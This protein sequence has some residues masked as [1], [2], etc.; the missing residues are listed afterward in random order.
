[1]DQ[2]FGIRADRDCYNAVRG[3]SHGHTRA[4]SVA[5][6]HMGNV[7]IH[8]HESHR[9][10][11][12]FDALRLGYVRDGDKEDI[13]T[14]ELAY[15]SHSFVPPPPNSTVISSVIGGPVKCAR[16]FSDPKFGPIVRPPPTEPF[17]AEAI[18]NL[19][20]RHLHPVESCLLRGSATN[21]EPHET[22]VGASPLL[23][24]VPQL[25]RGSSA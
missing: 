15:H 11:T 16:L 8:S 4:S 7:R 14:R 24:R 3:S 21:V 19:Q 25:C 5:L 6:L 1:M 22:H 20:L 10:V 9:G 17:E 12:L 13:L 18:M 2:V 23:T